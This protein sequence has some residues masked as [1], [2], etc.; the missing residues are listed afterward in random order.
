MADPDDSTTEQ[1]DAKDTARWKPLT[2][3]QRRVAGVLVEKAKTTPDGYPMTLNA[4]TTGCNQK[5]NRYPQMALAPEDVEETLDELRTLGAVAEVHTGGR[6]PKY[7]HYMYEWLGVDKH[8]IA[9]MTELLLR[10]AQT[11]GELRSRA[12]RMEPI[13]DLAALRSILEPLQE[14]NL[15]VE[16]THAG[17]GQVIAHGLYTEP[18]MAALKKRFSSGADATAGAADRRER[19]SAASGQFEQ[20][21]GEIDSLHADVEQLQQSIA[22]L[23]ERLDAGGQGQ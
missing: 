16:L 15:V 21:R 9:V 18:E 2:A 12:G 19:T 4:L 17:R 14:R 1:A 23:Q 20:I 7:R 8:Q 13:A 10:G 6:A 5:S 11:L 22:R 3:I